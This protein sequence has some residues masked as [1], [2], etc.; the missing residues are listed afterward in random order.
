ME[1]SDFIVQ[2][3]DKEHNDKTIEELVKAPV[4]AISG[5][6]QADEADLKKTFGI[7][8]VEDL[9]TN[10]YVR[11]A[12]GISSLSEC[13]GAHI[14]MIQGKVF[15]A[16]EYKNLA[17]TPISAVKGISEEQVALLKRALDVENIKELAE[18]KYVLIAQTTVTMAKLLLYVYLWDYS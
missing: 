3:Y 10:E 11:F 18:N 4:S 7:E 16:T 12:Q 9:A 13:S 14:Y 6:S 8:T 5:L 17:K 1:K 2:F 15:E